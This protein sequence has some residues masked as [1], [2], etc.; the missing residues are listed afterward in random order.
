MMLMKRIPA[1]MID[2]RGTI[3]GRDDRQIQKDEVSRMI[4]VTKPEKLEVLFRYGREDFQDLFRTPIPGLG[5][6][7]GR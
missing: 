5:G 3:I 6:V 7:V 1:S 2:P 4:L